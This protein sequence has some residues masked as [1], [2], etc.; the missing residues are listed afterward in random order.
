MRRGA[1]CRNNTAIGIRRS[2]VSAAGAKLGVRRLL[3]IGQSR[4]ASRR[5]AGHRLGLRRVGLN[6][7]DGGI[8]VGAPCGYEFG[9]SA[10]EHVDRLAPRRRSRSRNVLLDLFAESGEVDS[11]PRFKV[12][13][14]RFTLRF[15][16]LKSGFARLSLRHDF[17]FYPAEDR[18][19]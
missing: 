12:M 5:G 2:C 1:T 13:P 14:L 16:G 19:Q 10:V 3:D 6:S 4:A 15:V 18:L 9:G 8:E 7:F 17:R 11:N